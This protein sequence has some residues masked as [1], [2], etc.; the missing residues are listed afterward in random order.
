M[1]KEF[2]FFG[3]ATELVRGYVTA[4]NAE[5][6]KQKLLE[7]EYDDIVD[8]YDTRIKE[9]LEITEYKE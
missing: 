6:A 9:V 2:K 5:E 1:S 4:E 3:V 7:N 8:S